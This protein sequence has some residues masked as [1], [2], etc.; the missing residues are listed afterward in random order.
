M[1][2]VEALSGRIGASDVRQWQEVK[3]G[4]T[5]FQDGDVLFAKITPCMENGKAAIARGVA[6]GVGTGSMEFHVLR[7][8]PALRPEILLH[9]VLREEFRV[10]PGADDRDCR[11]TSRSEPVS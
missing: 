4:Y 6:G 2:S 7:P 10:C 5:R 8:G 3:K 11:S 1:A 9:Y